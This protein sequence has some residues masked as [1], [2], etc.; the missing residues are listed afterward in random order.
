MATGAVPIDAPGEVFVPFFLA[1][2]GDPILR[3]AA[4]VARPVPAAPV[5]PLRVHPDAG[6]PAGDAGGLLA[7]P[8]IEV[9]GHAQGA[10][11]D[12]RSARPGAPAAV[13]AGRRV[14]ASGIVWF[15]AT[16]LGLSPV[17]YGVPWA[18]IGAAFFM[19]LNLALLLAAI[20]R[21][22]SSTL[23]GNRRAGTRL[24]VHVPV[25]LAGLPGELVD[26]SVTG[27]GVR[28]EAPVDL[29]R[30]RA[31]AD[32]GAAHRSARAAGRD[33]AQP[34]ASDGPRCSGLS[35]TPGQEQA[36]GELAV[37]VFHA[38]VATPRRARRRRTHG[39][40]GGS[41]PGDSDLERA[42]DGRLTAGQSSS[43][44]GAD[45]PQ[46]GERRPEQRPAQVLDAARAAGPA[47]RADRPFDHL[48][49]AVAPLLDALVEVDQPLGDER[50]V[51]VARGRRR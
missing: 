33:P 51:R 6:R 50:G 18:A 2:L 15:T 36:V 8:G 38:D 29:R 22:R 13:R 28:I 17:T 41:R 45:L 25:R 49:V 48:H 35:F 42:R 39:R 1:T 30:R 19:A 21:I 14:L 27:A 31:V 40:V 24:P 34:D 7:R 23:R 26:L 11:R 10:Q 46:V 44:S 43:Q 47:L 9:Q 3:A 12:E 32:D 20:Q 4:P 5:G 37:A 16:L